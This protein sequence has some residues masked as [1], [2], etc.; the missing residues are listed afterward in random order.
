ML[1]IGPIPA[2]LWGE[3]GDR[4]ILAVH[5][6]MSH[7]ADTVI[8]L[9]A[10]QA[11][12]QGYRVLSFDLPQHGDRKDEPTLCKAQICVEELR[13]VM[14]YAKT[15][16]DDISLFGC[17]MG[18]YFSLLAYGGEP[19]RQALFLS[20]VVD[21]ERLIGNMMTWFSVS[22]KRLQAEGE[23]S[24]PT[25][26]TLDWGDYQYVKAHPVTRWVAPTHILY[27]SADQLCERDT[28]A[29]FTGQFGC[30]LTVLEGGEH[31]FHTD[32]QLKAYQAWVRNI[33]N[34]S[35]EEGTR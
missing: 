27:G 24:T 32:E 5:G 23:V 11:V 7:K 1:H 21:M 3:S 30:E 17:S 14:R 9:L 12:A 26:Q 25:G 35:S 8:A 19:L 20:P 4:L 15:L 13:S 29:H 2:R 34:T 18:A 33:L 10:Q 28:I 31:F 22:E 6:N 16:A